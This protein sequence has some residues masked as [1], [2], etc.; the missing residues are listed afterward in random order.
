MKH[1]LYQNILD[2]D[3]NL[4]KSPGQKSQ[5]VLGMVKKKRMWTVSQGK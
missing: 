2:L 4:Q 3:L 5:V 1:P